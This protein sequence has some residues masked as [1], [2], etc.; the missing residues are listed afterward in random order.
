LEKTWGPAASSASRLI[1]GN[2]TSGAEELVKKVPR[3]HVVSAFNI[4][5]SE[6]LFGVFEAKR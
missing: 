3:A 1:M 4:V 6:V 5:P 2:T